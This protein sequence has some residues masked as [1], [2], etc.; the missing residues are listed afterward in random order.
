VKRLQ[1][2]QDLP[3]FLEYSRRTTAF[4]NVYDGASGAV[5]PLASFSCD[6]D[7]VEHPYQ[8]GVALIGDAAAISDPVYGQ[9]M[10]LTLRDVRTLSEKLLSQ[11]DRDKAA[12]PPLN[13]T[14]TFP[15]FTPAAGG[16][17]KSFRSRDLKPIDDAPLRC[18]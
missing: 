18:P 12:M 6:E 4:P 10:S 11:S 8:N 16:Y 7:W 13:T 1:G 9:G 14:A 5:G 15:R 17:G 2:E 3:R